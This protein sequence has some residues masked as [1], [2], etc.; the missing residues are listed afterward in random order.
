MIENCPIV[1]EEMIDD[2]I[3]SIL[4]DELEGIIEGE[5]GSQTVVCNNEAMQRP[6]SADIPDSQKTG[7]TSLTSD[8]Q[9]SEIGHFLAS[10]CSDLRK[11]RLELSEADKLVENAVSQLSYALK[12]AQ[13]S[14]KKRQLT[15]LDFWKAEAT[16][17]IQTIRHDHCSTSIPSGE[18]I[19]SPASPILFEL[20]DE[21]TDQLSSVKG[22][23]IT[24]LDVDLTRFEKVPIKGDGNCLFYSV[25]YFIV[26]PHSPQTFSSVQK[27]RA[28][29]ATFMEENRSHF[30]FT[31]DYGESFEDHLNHIRNRHEYGAEPEIRAME[32]QNRIPIITYDASGIVL[33]GPSDDVDFISP[34][35]PIYLLFESSTRIADS[36]HYSALT[37]LCD[38]TQY[39]DVA[40]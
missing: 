25:N 8:P 7:H 1:E 11:R 13:E 18:Q 30:E 17:L 9:L 39:L 40:S 24:A 37:P 20:L 4:N 3:T 23:R 32:M 27:L 34:L 16:P 10:K 21:E 14:T 19:G 12:R 5:S 36:G 15:V 31:N 22:S 33:R 6:K 29:V 28:D 38:I 35:R 26:G 2:A